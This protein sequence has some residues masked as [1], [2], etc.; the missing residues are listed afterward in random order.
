MGPGKTTNFLVQYD[1]TIAN[2]DKRAQAL[3][4]V[5]ESEYTAMAGWF[6][7][8]ATAFGTGD[9][10]TVN[11]NKAENSGAVNYGYSSGGGSNMSLDTQ[12]SNANDAGAAEIIKMLFMAE[13]VEIF[14]SY[15]DQ[16]IASTYWQAG[17]SSGEGLSQY[18]TIERFKTGHYSYYGSWIAKW[19]DSPSTRQDWVSSTEGTDG[20]SVSFGCALLFIYYL[21]KQLGFSIN[22]ILAAYN[23]NLK[24]VYNTLTGDAGN[25]F[26]FFK[27][28]MDNAYPV[29]PASLP[30]T[31][32]DDP[33]PLGLLSFWMDKNTFGKDEVQDAINT[34]GGTFPN[35]FFLMVEGFNLNT[36]E[37]FGV[38]VLSS[39][40]G[41]FKDFPG[42]SITQNHIVQEITGNPNIP[43]RIRV[44]FDVSFTIDSVN[45][46]PTS[47]DVELG[48]NASIMIGGNAV[49]GSQTS[50]IFELLAGA[51]PYF[52]N[53]DPNQNNV[54]YL[55]QDLRLFTA[56]P[57]L[58]SNPVGGGAP[59]F[60]DDSVT[61]A[62]NYAQ[63][64]ITFLNNSYNNPTG[65]DPFSSF[66]PGQ[67]TTYTADSSVTKNTASGGNL[68]QNYNFAIA[69]VRLRGTAG[70]IGAAHN[71]K[72]FFRLWSTQTPD[73]DYQPD[74]TYA[75]TTIGGKPE[76]PLIGTGNTTI[77]FFATGN[78]NANSD[79]SSGG[80][81][82]RLI[83]INTGD[84]VW[85]YF[86]CFLNIYDSTY[87]IN[88][89]QIQNLLNGTHHCIVAQIAYDD[90]PVITNMSPENSDKLAQRNLQVTYSDNPGI[91]ATHRIPQ[92]FDI[93][94]GIALSRNN[95]II[96]DYPDELMIDWGNTPAGSTANI[97]WP[98]VNASAVLD[99]A[100]QIYGTHELT[101]SDPHT[102][103]CKVTKGVTYVPIPSDAGENF[104]GL[105]TVDLPPTVVSGQVLNIIVRRVSSKEKSE[106]TVIIK[107]L[108][109]TTAPPAK[110]VIDNQN[111]NEEGRVG[112]NNQS[113][114]DVKITRWRYVTGTFQVK[115]PVTHKSVMLH[116]EEDTLAVMKWRLQTMSPANRWYPV[117]QRYIT[118]IAGR[119]NGL[120]G[121]ADAIPPSLE[122][123]PVRTID[124]GKE[125]CKEGKK[126]TDCCKENLKI[127][128]W[129]A[130]GFWSLAVIA[131]IANRNRKNH[132]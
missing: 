12:T 86:G 115:I 33:F 132:K 47:G 102:L 94:P 96:V 118:Y 127:T 128:S 59:S 105:F 113:D 22:Q 68:F 40:N 37:S 20:N 64:L 116:P 89:Q 36:F 42:V 71:V 46:F 82:N 15:N 119:I 31:T 88:G 91:P 90:A 7:I 80:I 29:S 34:T 25:P 70:S 92:T 28:L 103:H 124:N 93:R 55:S 23:S 6:N 53:I 123:R 60:S 8:P 131:I 9:R 122:G 73:T 100:S 4:A 56:T 48:L 81:N 79:Y 49:T 85:A 3:L 95:G 112:I 125:N 35:A 129:A 83:Q 38:N 121:N 51:D 63:S 65:I 19:L 101:A 44:A 1:D 5:V 54:F 32:P 97:Y 69:R 75:S 84:Q 18:C 74:T 111:N 76:A 45:H 57:S 99:L 24:S 30:A 66:L 120:G 16:K 72:V 21:N 26:P 62:Y 104:A 39:L 114:S 58:A 61:G 108:G 106:S 107:A 126:G 98:R 17:D 50:T 67:S 14:M 13:F 77:P 110:G 2:S 27:R 52:T 43:Q 109:K 130:F 41:T 10:I 78:I 87:L 11:I 117:L